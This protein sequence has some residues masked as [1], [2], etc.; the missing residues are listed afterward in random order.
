MMIIIHEKSP[1][2]DKA[3]NSVTA[4]FIAKKETV[5]LSGG[6]KGAAQHAEA[7]YSHFKTYE[8]KAE[9][10]TFVTIQPT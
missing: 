1:L 10:I 2:F 6:Q 9:H 4:L 7:P 3:L 8:E 5:K